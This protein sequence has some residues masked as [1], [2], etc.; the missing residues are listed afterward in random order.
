MAEEHHQDKVYKHPLFSGKDP[1]KY[2]EHCVKFTS[3]ADREGFLEAL[4]RTF[5]ED[6]VDPDSE[7]EEVIKRIKM[8]KKA[9]HNLMQS[10][11]ED[12]FLC[13]SAGEHDERS[14]HE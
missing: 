12:A 1:S 2:I 13:V 3:C 8:V 5:T 4:E 10:T 6:E 7:D 9:K 11:A 14:V